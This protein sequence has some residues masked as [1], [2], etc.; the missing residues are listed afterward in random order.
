MVDN[1]KKLKEENNK[2]KS[3]ISVLKN[4]LL[5][6]EKDKLAAATLERQQMLFFANFKKIMEQ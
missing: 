3:Q 6:A 4:K 5:E 1:L 2:L